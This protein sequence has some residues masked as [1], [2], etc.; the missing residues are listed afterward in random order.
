MKKGMLKYYL[1]TLIL[2][3]ILGLLDYF[4]TLF[5]VFDNMTVFIISRVYF[6]FF[7]LSA[8]AIPLFSHKKYPKSSLILPIYQVF[9]YVIFYS[10]AMVVTY[11]NLYFTWGWIVIFSLGIVSSV[12]EILAAIYLLRRFKLIKY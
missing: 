7:I 5:Y 2:V 6:L 8:V 9:V 1:I 3:N 4:F 12:V 11:F 10:S